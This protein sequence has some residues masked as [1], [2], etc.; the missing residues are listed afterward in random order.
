MEFPDKVVNFRSETRLD[1]NFNLCGIEFTLRWL[2][3]KVKHNKPL[4]TVQKTPT[5]MK[6]KRK[7]F[8]KKQTKVVCESSW[9]GL[10]RVCLSRS[11]RFSNQWCSACA[12]LTRRIMNV[13]IKALRHRSRFCCYFRAKLFAALARV[14]NLCSCCFRTAVAYVTN[15]RFRLLF[16]S[17]R[18]PFET[19]CWRQ[20][21]N[22]DVRQTKFRWS[23]LS[24]TIESFHVNAHRSFSMFDLCF[25]KLPNEKFQFLIDL[26]AMIA[27]FNWY[28]WWI[29][30]MALSFFCS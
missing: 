11:L 28:L 19:V 10:G 26:W 13:R 14:L 21:F 3:T 25:I 20:T 8:S 27:S 15:G 29:L 22:W 4:P 16:L 23:R 18:C 12:L 7:T 5:T 2:P 9:K 17:S 6:A 1:F 30:A 24:Q